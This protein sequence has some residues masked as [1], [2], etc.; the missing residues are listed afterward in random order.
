MDETIQIRQVTVLPVDQLIGLYQDLGWW[1]ESRYQRASIPKLITG[2]FCFFAAFH[3]D[4][5]V[6]IGRVLSDGVSDAYLH[7][8]GVHSNYRRRG[9]GKELVWRLTAYCME[10]DL[11]WIGLI[12]TPENEEWYRKCGYERLTG[13]HPMLYPNAHFSG[14]LGIPNR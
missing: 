14:S 5:L 13:Y 9:I 12:A 4:R 8:I 1:T 2:S 6:G 11:E 7:E 3:G 10:K